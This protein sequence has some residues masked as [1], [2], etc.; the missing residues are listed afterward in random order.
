METMM[1]FV[2]G[3]IRNQPKLIS[4]V[5]DK[6]KID[7]EALKKHGRIIEINEAQIFN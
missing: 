3:H 5:G 7:L 6:S 1:G 2:D 4:I